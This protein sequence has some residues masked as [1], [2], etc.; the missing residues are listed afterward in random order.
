MN[1]YLQK[2]LLLNQ[3]FP[4]FA[5]NKGAA[6][7]LPRTI[8]GLTCWYDASDS[9]TI[10]IDTGVSQWNDKS[11]NGNNLT[12]GTAS[13]QPTVQTANL[14]GL[15]T[16]RFDGT[17]DTME[18]AA[19]S[20]ALS[21]P[22]TIYMVFSHLA[23]ASTANIYDGISSLERHSFTS[24]LNTFRIIAGSNLVSEATFTGFF[25]SKNLYNTNIGNIVAVNGYEYT[26]TTTTVGT[27]DLGGFKVAARFDDAQPANIDVAEI[28]IYDNEVS[29]ANEALIYEYFSNKWN[30]YYQNKFAN[31]LLWLNAN[32]TGTFTTATGIDLW[33]DMSGNTHDFSQA[34]GSKQPALQS[35]AMNG[36]DTARF[37]GTNDI[38][39]RANDSAFQ[40]EAEDFYI[41]VVANVHNATNTNSFIGKYNTTTNNREFLSALA[42][43]DG[44]MRFFTSDDG[45]SFS[46]N[47]TDDT[48]FADN[49]DRMFEFE[50]I[51]DEVT[52]YEDGVVQTNDGNNIDTDLFTGTAD[53]AI[54]GL[55]SEVASFFLDGDIA[56][57]F[58]F[59]GT[60]TDAQ[61]TAIRNYLTEKWGL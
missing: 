6:V 54:G 57:I 49:T 51:G 55:D 21:Q 24:A 36:L 28:L 47:Q 20:S 48:D 26:N 11:S 33:R 10:T 39:E 19:F 3:Q 42:A 60:L 56:E 2:Q 15:D 34:T 53:I 13:M 27:Q 41:F 45:T 61:K 43:T 16:I 31:N 12:Q 8:P 58:M 18:T 22:N 38:L 1:P 44:F 23:P 46:S 7:G 50:K 37:D 17:D 30:L 25:I 9:S 5:F 35:A 14:N 29:A 32:V 40:F 4:G 59:T 52:F